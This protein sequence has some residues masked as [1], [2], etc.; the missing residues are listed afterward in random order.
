MDLSESDHV[1]LPANLITPP[2]E[3]PQASP[4]L[5]PKFLPL[6]MR[7]EPHTA[8]R[9]LGLAS[10]AAVNT[11]LGIQTPELPALLSLPRFPDGCPAEV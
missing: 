9:I 7:Q 11:A 10:I 8:F 2:G 5:Y 4:H 3:G 6:P 1:P